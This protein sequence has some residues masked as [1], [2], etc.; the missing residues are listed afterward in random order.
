MTFKKELL[1]SQKGLQEFLTE[2][3]SQLKMI[4]DEVNVGYSTLRNYAYGVTPLDSMPYRLV[5]ALT[6]YVA[7]NDLFHPTFGIYL[8]EPAFYALAKLAGRII[9]TSPRAFAIEEFTK[10]A[11]L[12]HQREK[13]AEKGKPFPPRYF[14]VDLKYQDD[15]LNEYYKRFDE[16]NHQLLLQTTKQLQNMYNWPDE[17]LSQ[18]MT[19]NETSIMLKS[20]DPRIT[21]QL[22]SLS[23]PRTGNRDLS[24]LL[25]GAHN[26]HLI[27]TNKI[28]TDGR[29]S[30]WA[31]KDIDNMFA[32][33]ELQLKYSFN[34]SD[35]VLP[36][37]QI[38]P[39][40]T[41]AHMKGVDFDELRL[42]DDEAV[43]E[44]I[45]RNLINLHTATS[46]EDIWSRTVHDM[47]HKQLTLHHNLEIHKD[48]YMELLGGAGDFV[49]SPTIAN[50]LD[51]IAMQ[52]AKAINQQIDSLSRP[53]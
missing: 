43:R 8:D 20:T 16:D 3:K 12:L 1:L 37:G 38:V 47:L 13:E 50:T 22:F 48:S 36:S 5:E 26:I 21:N 41:V 53:I 52:T 39:T 32:I 24:P 27:V 46:Y 31:L 30:R 6:R 28:I 4:A 2:N 19:Q 44:R 14:F 18:I 40:E 35:W 25:R 23:L 42:P 9:E 29:I 10:A 7:P 11:L 33:V 51:N 15:F 17:Q 49:Q 34:G 45:Y